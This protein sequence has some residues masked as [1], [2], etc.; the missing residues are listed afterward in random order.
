MKKI[1]L[2]KDNITPAEAL[3]LAQQAYAEDM[4]RKRGAQLIGTNHDDIALL[5]QAATHVGLNILDAL[6]GDKRYG[7]DDYH[8]TAKVEEWKAFIKGETMKRQE[9]KIPF[10]PFERLFGNRPVGPPQTPYMRMLDNMVGLEGVKK[11]VKEIA[12]LMKIRNERA[13]ANLTVV[14]MP[15]HMVFTGNPGTGKTTV[16]RI[17]GEILRETGV[18]TKGHFIEVSGRGLVAEYVGQTEAKT[19]EIITEA[20]DGVLFIDE[21]YALVPKDSHRDFGPEAVAALIKM[22]EDHRNRLVVIVAG[23]ENEMEGLLNSNPGLKSRFKTKIDFPDYSAEELAQIFKQ[24]CK[25]HQYVLTKEATTRANLLFTEMHKAKGEHFGNGRSVRNTFERCITRQ[26]SRLMQ[27][28]KPS[29][30]D[31]Q[32]L[33]GEDIPPLSEVEW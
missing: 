30:K 1:I 26:A 23:Y 15:M 29:H 20:L 31:L 8:R 27:V 18:L 4:F 25:E 5:Y 12:S 33:K 32:T 11:Q 3:S 9:T 22:M 14:D 24:L 19:R 13:N 10:N 28:R 16:A 17:V 2:K 7:I 6:I 21:A